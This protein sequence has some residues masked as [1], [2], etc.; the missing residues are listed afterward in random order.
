[1]GLDF[2]WIGFLALVAFLTRVINLT[3]IPIFTDEAI[4]IRWGQIG[5]ADPAHRYISLT[6]GKQPLLTWLMYPFLHFF[7]DP[8]FA[9]RL[10]SVCA[11][12]ASC[13]GMYMVGKELFGRRTGI[14]AALLYIITPFTLVYDRL[15]LMDGLHATIGIW[16]MYLTV[17]LVR[18]IRLDVALL[19]GLVIG[20]G[21]LNKS[22][23]LF[24]LLLLPFSLLLFDWK[25]KKHVKRL[26]QW[27]GLTLVSAAIA[28]IMSQSLRLSP[29]FYLIKQKD[30]VFI[31][32]V[33]EFLKEPFSLLQG[34]LTG[35]L[36]MTYEYLTLPMNILIIAGS[37]WGL[38]RY[39]GITAY[40]LVWFLFPFLALASFGKIIFPRYML[41][42]CIPLLLIAAHLVSIVFDEARKRSVG[43]SGLLPF[44]FF[45]LYF[46]PTLYLVFL[47]LFSPVHAAIPRTDRN[48]L[49]DE[50]PS[51]YG[52][53]EVIDY[54]REQAKTKKI[55]IGTEGTFGLSPAV[56]EI[57]LGND[58]NVEIH[59]Y[60]PVGEVPLELLE[61]ARQHPTYLVFKEAQSEKNFSKWPMRLIKKI[62]RG[63]GNTYLYF[64]E[65]I[66]L[67]REGSGA[68]N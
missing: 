57:Y 17:V 32:T 20:L 12:V 50:W 67:E 66:P 63:T 11:G 10:V 9:A 55:V 49:F 62:Q 19:L 35:M 37:I 31:V 45:P 6:D 26:L 52:V 60:W 47:L 33:P 4:Y 53:M 43:V 24:Y 41:F 25:Q 58:P 5:L 14:A 42:M 21:Y 61:K 64:Y 1:M 18:R 36:P 40:L 3:N 15:A 48:Q 51:G 44:V 39:T 65:V 28:L 22:S 2:L 13:I 68:G 29:W 30:H 56:Y 27:G 38:I 23:S 8:L 16:S 7:G 54:L 34:N 59:G 46:F